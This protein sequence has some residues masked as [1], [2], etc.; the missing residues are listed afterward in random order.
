MEADDQPKAGLDTTDVAELVLLVLMG[1]AREMEDAARAVT[2]ELEAMRRKKNVLR[3]LLERLARESE[4]VEKAL[5]CEYEQAF[6]STENGELESLR[7]QM[8]MDRVSKTMSTLS[9]ILKKLSDTQSSITQNL[10]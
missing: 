1:A 5:R 9:N 4:A 6:I 3:D 7:L 2:E 10:K 8:A